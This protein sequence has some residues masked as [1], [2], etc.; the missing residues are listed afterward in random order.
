MESYVKDPTVYPVVFSLGRREMTLID[1]RYATVTFCVSGS[2]ELAQGVYFCDGNYIT[3][4]DLTSEDN[5]VFVKDRKTSVFEFFASSTDISA[6]TFSLKI[7]KDGTSFS[8]FNSGSYVNVRQS[9]W[10][11][12][13]TSSLF[14]S[15]NSMKQ[16]SAVVVDDI[17]YY[18]SVNVA[19]TF[20]VRYN[21]PYT[22]T[23]FT[24]TPGVSFSKNT[25]DDGNRGVLSMLA[26]LSATWFYDFARTLPV[27]SPPSELFFGK[28]YFVCRTFMVVPGYFSYKASTGNDGLCI[29][30]GVFT[31]D[32][33]ISISGDYG[34]FCYTGNNTYDGGRYFRC[35]DDVIVD[36]NGYCAKPG[37]ISQVYFLEGDSSSSS[38]CSS[39]S[40]SCSS[41]SCSG[42][43]SSVSS[44]SCSM[45]SSSCSSSSYSGVSSSCS[46]SSCS[47]S[48]SSSSCSCSSSS[49]SCSSCSCSSSSLSSSSS[50]SSAWEPPQM[51]N[52]LAAW[53]YGLSG[54]VGQFGTWNGQYGTPINT[55]L[56][57]NAVVNTNGLVLDGTGDYA[58]IGP[59]TGINST[60]QFTIA[61][62]AKKAVVTDY[63]P[64]VESFI[65]F[66]V[67]I[68]LSWYSNGDV[69]FIARTEDCPLQYI[70]YT[71]TFT[72]DWVHFVGVY[73]GSLAN[74][75]RLKLYINT[76]PVGSYG[77]PGELVDTAMEIDSGLVFK[78]G[79]RDSSE[80]YDK[81]YIDNVYIYNKALALSEIQEI[82][83]NDPYK[84]V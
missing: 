34:S 60:T 47:C 46:S 70:E 35:E 76:T 11:G 44:C 52:L 9:P 7:W 27:S 5:V 48:S 74:E 77:I 37:N 30:N 80:E 17:S 25:V 19:I 61:F 31:K 10:V 58:N 51:G 45:S 21:T 78:V 24:L 1:N 43:S 69:Y 4:V 49:S 6:A 32:Y 71:K 79:R 3:D 39:S 42:C 73:N 72:T 53:V 82:Y 56:Y 81:G 62:W 68:H 33:V 15:N 75:D 26:E 13:T 59:V 55:P 41:S 38:S 67:D 16:F 54:N 8:V 20:D 65:S 28:K 83:N 36:N 12:A 64:R 50:C 66:P 14:Y 40:C 57:D 29:V 18:P 2:N 84:R 23:G 63:G 22:V